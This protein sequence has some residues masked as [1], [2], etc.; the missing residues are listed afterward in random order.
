MEFQERKPGRREPPAQ[1]SYGYYPEEQ[2]RPYVYGTRQTHERTAWYSP[3]S[4]SRKVWIIVVVVIVLIVAIAIAV[5]VV[6]TQTSKNAY[7]DYDEVAYSL[8]ETCKWM[9]N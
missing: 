3:K 2:D 6:V 8:A 4:W 1:D 5:P 7:P 9:K